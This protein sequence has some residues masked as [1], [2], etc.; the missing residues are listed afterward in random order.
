VYGEENVVEVEERVT[1]ELSTSRGGKMERYNGERKAYGE[2]V[3][4][5]IGGRESFVKGDPGE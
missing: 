4:R 2:D 5:R 1:L 3:Y